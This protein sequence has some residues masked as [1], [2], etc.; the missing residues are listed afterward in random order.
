MHDLPNHVCVNFCIS[1]LVHYFSFMCDELGV[2]KVIKS[3]HNPN[4]LQT[5]YH[6]LW[7]PIN[8]DGNESH[9]SLSIA[10]PP[11]VSLTFKDMNEWEECE[12]EVVRDAFPNLQKLFLWCY[13]QK[14]SSSESRV[15]WFVPISLV[16]CE[17]RLTDCKSMQ[18]DYS[19]CTLKFLKICWCCT[20]GSFVEW[21]YILSH[22]HPSIKTLSIDDF[23]ATNIPI[24]N[25][26]IFR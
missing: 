25:C 18:F 19:R 24:D 26:Y 7:L 8:F 3:L 14:L 13:I 12:C 1:Q 17:L 21:I 5:F 4:R 2:S 16:I 10:F 15:L 20:E 9:S 22:Y 11:L 6:S 23:A